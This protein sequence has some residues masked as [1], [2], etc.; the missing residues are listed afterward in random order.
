[1]SF[2]SDVDIARLDR[3]P[4]YAAQTARHLRRF[5]RSVFGAPVSAL[6]AAQTGEAQPLK[7]PVSKRT[8]LP[9]A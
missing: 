9:L 8:L 5:V 2:V 7:A 1:M 4:L 3:D 6:P